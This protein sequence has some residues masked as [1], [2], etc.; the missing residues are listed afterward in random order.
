MPVT[1]YTTDD[2]YP[3]FGDFT[4]D[5]E[6]QLSKVF[7]PE[8]YA[9]IKWMNEEENFPDALLTYEL[10]VQNFDKFTKAKA[11]KIASYKR[12]PH[13]HGALENAHE[14]EAMINDKD[15]ILV[16]QKRDIEKPK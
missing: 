11:Y 4:E 9:Y 3:V 10:Q 12:V 2:F 16:G 7:T 8:D 1:I 13:N 6:A 14:K 15:F 5:V